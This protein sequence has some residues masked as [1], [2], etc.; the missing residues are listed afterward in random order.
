M[1]KC[2]KLASTQGS[3]Q[4]GLGC[5]RAFMEKGECTKK[6]ERDGDATGKD[7]ELERE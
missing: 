5:T 7:K 4:K 3:I 1:V 2:R 6:M